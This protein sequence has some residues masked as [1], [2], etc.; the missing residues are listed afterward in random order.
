MQSKYMWH[1]HVMYKQTSTN[2][3]SMLQINV[4]LPH[5]YVCIVDCIVVLQTKSTT[6]VGA[7]RNIIVGSSTSGSSIGSCCHSYLCWQFTYVPQMCFYQ[8]HATTFCPRK[9]NNDNN[10]TNSSSSCRNNKDCRRCLFSYLFLY[11]VNRLFSKVLFYQII[12]L[13]VELNQN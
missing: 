5:T 9:N 4:S 2:T 7:F 3:R 13:E 11:Q 12:K 1:C 8:M 10:N 6:C